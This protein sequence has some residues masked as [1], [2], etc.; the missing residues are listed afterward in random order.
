MPAPVLPPSANRLLAAL[1]PDEYA[2]LLPYLTVVSLANRTDLH[3]KDQRLEA[4]YF[5]LDGVAS[6]TTL[7]ADGGMVEIGTTGWEGLV[8]LHAFFGADTC[9]FQ[10]FVQV[11][12]TFARLPLAAFRAAVS[13]S[14][15]LHGILL[16]YSQ[17]HY[18]LAGQSAGCNRLHPVERRC[19]RWLLLT[20]DRVGLKARCPFS[21]IPANI[22]SIGC[23][24]IRPDM[25][26]ISA[27][28]SGASPAIR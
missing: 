12:G 1:P 24:A 17:A 5:P 23:S 15:A 28:R 6:L 18:V 2:R 4:V 20:H 14:T 26:A 8:G 9:P 7:M 10:A 3:A 21:P 22:T 11:P 16:A 25:R 13:P 19:A 27:C